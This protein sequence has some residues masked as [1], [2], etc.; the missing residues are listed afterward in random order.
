M[1]GKGWEIFLCNLNCTH[2]FVASAGISAFIGH[3]KLG[4][5]ISCP[6][7]G[8]PH[9]PKSAGLKRLWDFMVSVLLQ[10]Y[11]S[12]NGIAQLGGL[13]AQGC[14]CTW[15]WWNASSP[16]IHILHPTSHFYLHLTSL[17]HLWV[18]IRWMVPVRVSVSLHPPCL[19]IFTRTY[20]TEWVWGMKAGLRS[21]LCTLSFNQTKPGLKLPKL[22]FSAMKSC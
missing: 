7:R 16:Q 8:F 20:P 15:S 6:S 17:S 5:F 3:E 10:V 13:W 11:Y 4:D 12:G 18:R 9:P 14:D 1:K 21:G 2:Q 19:G 22:L